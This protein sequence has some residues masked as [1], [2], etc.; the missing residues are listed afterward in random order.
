MKKTIAAA[1]LSTA[2]SLTLASAVSA[3]GEGGKVIAPPPQNN[4]VTTKLQLQTAPFADLSGH[5]AADAVNRLTSYQMIGMGKIGGPVPSF[6]PNSRADR[7]ELRAWIRN[8][9]GK[10]VVD[11]ATSSAVTRVEAA[12]WVASSLP[13]I[14]IGINGA[15]LSAPYDD[16]GNVTPTER[17]A[18]NLLYKLGIMVGDGHGHFNPNGALTRGEAAVV[19]D[20]AMER[21]LA[22]ASK[23]DFEKVSEPLPEAVQTIAYENRKQPGVYTTVV[24]DARYVVICAG[25]VSSAG[26]SV[27]VD[28][29]SET[30]AG[31]FIS[32]SLQ[33]PQ[34]G[35]VAQP[36]VSYPQ[37][38]LKIKDTDKSVYLAQ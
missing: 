26:Y 32:A 21:T 22:V 19:L 29:L 35:T 15:N 17:N 38:T 3:D 24:D 36:T 5:F 14:N 34:P 18:L 25:E 1:F 8:A 16:I 6:A 37:T 12:T 30:A 9:L 7:V 10:E 20:Q 13:E 27:K 2:L 4:A 33:H 23:A 28:S 11:T 31:I